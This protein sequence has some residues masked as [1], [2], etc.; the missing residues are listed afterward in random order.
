MKDPLRALGTAGLLLAS[1][2]VAVVAAASPA[3][4]DTRICDKYGSTV[5]DRYVVMN[6]LWAS[7]TPQCITATNSGFAIT[8]ANHNKRT[9]GAP[10]SYTAIYS[11]CH[12]ANCS[13]GANLPMQV[14]QIS[15]ATSSA[16]FSYPGSNGVYNAAYDIW[17][18]PTP[19]Q[20]GENQLELMVWFDKQGPI[21][22]FGSRT[23]TATVGGRT[24]EVWTGDAPTRRVV[25]YAAPSPITSW[26]FNVQD[27]INDV[28]TQSKLTN[29]WYLTSIQAG[30]EPWVGGAG[31]AVTSFAANV[32][33]GG[34]STQQNP[35][36][37]PAKPTPS[38]EPTQHPSTPATPVTPP[39]QPATQPSPSTQ[40]NPSTQPSPSTQ[41]KA[42]GRTCV[43]QAGDTL[44]GI[45]ERQHV[46]GG[47]RSLYEHN[48]KLV[49][50]DPNLILPGQRLAL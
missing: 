34:G 1:S 28:K 36:N 15:S 19:K 14:S 44:S 46:K 4:A 2:V 18:D 50:A 39:S 40:P 35:P 30:F 49:G 13:P 41:P 8:T 43:V 45:A 9:N 27:F 16:S 33:G 29:S 25:S 42:D 21:H 26:N 31:L 3:H 10:V 6:N 47:W 5:Q 24:W 38:A 17:L 37:Q 12:Y 22:P 32:N 23:G 20:N 7:D 48:R 11:G